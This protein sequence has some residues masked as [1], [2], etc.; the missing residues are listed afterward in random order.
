MS[1]YAIAVII[2]VA[3]VA[4]LVVAYALGFT[5]HGFDFSIGILKQ[6]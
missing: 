6:G 2:A 4:A 1:W 5:I 3:A